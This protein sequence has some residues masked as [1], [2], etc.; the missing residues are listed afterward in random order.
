MR[1]L[2][3][4][5]MLLFSIISIAQDIKISTID[6]VQ[7]QND[8]REEAI[9]Y[10]EN[11][12]LV[13]RKMALEREFI[14]SYEIIE[15][16]ATDDAPFH[17]ILK[18]TYADQASFDKAEDRFQKLIEEKGPLQLLNEKKPGDFRKVIFSKP[19]AKHLF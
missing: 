5:S 4:F 12:W 7:V 18:T 15:V 1:A 19:D 6:F 16:E 2:F 9:F 17:L 8:N 10:Y 14:D 3:F 13:L 11:N